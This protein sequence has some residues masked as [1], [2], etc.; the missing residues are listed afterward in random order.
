MK[1]PRPHHSSLQFA[2][3]FGI[4]TVR[5]RNS[6]AKPNDGLGIN[7]R[8]SILENTA[9]VHLVIAVVGA[10]AL[11]KHQPIS[12]NPKTIRAGTLHM[13]SWNP[14]LHIRFPL[15]KCL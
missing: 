8:F 9:N 15:R 2:S 7:I 13:G 6:T 3:L 11:R 12:T 14:Q 5:M 10:R 1:V 4:Q